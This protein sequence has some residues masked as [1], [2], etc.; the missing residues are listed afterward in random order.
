MENKKDKFNGWGVRADILEIF[1]KQRRKLVAGVLAGSS[2][3]FYD[4]LLTATV[5]ALVWPF[6]FAPPEAGL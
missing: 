2:I 4:Y 3:E 1:K 6:V 5:A